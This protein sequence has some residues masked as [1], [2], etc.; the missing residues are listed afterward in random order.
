MEMAR[1]RGSVLS[2]SLI[3]TTRLALR[4]SFA[5]WKQG[6]FGARYRMA[7]SLASTPI[8]GRHGTVIRAA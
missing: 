1:D 2:R 6:L 5:L 3:S 7:I 4:S 8:E